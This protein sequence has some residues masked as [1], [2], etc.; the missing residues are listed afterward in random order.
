MSRLR[1]SLACWN[2]D[3]TRA[4]QDGRVVPDGLDVNYIPLPVE[5]TFFRMVRHREFDVSEMS[6]ST[7]VLSLFGE[8]KPFVAIPVFPSKC[9]RHSGIFVNREKKIRDPKDLMGRKV[10]LPEYQLT[11]CVWIRGIMSDEYGVPVD[12]VTY[13][14]GGEEEPGRS[15]KLGISLPDRIKLNAIPE[16]STL[17]AMLESGDID[18]LYSPRAPLNLSR[19]GRETSVVRLFPDYEARE[20]EY[21]AKTKIFPVMHVIA[22]RR[23]IYER[24]P[25]IAT[26]LY[27]AFQDSQ[28]MAYEELSA[29]NVLAYMDPWLI[30]H[31][32]ET[33]ELMGPDYWSYGLGPNRKTIEKFL[34]YSYDQGLAKKLLTPEEIFVKGTTESFKI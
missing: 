13:Y 1:I 20:R 31:V 30:S 34:R 15:E 8:E 19:P 6:L 18:A 10:G 25:W 21:F 5:E 23:E 16:G 2:Y 9:F 33:K 3:R 29:T 4:L 28:R 17:S 12:S 27:K 14:S 26:S 22:I 24:N 7:Y 32:E 11:A